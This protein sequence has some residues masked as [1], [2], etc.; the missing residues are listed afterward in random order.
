MRAAFRWW[1]RGVRQLLTPYEGRRC[2]CR[3]RHAPPPNLRTHVTPAVLAYWRRLGWTTHVVGQAAYAHSPDGHHH[4][5]VGVWG[6]RDRRPLWA[7]RLGRI[8]EGYERRR[9][10]CWCEQADRRNPDAAWWTWPLP[11]VY[12]WEGE[13]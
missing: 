4:L 9:D 3:T 2:E 1:S 10:R 11:V 13:R 6:R 8:S 7:D 5:L 12:R